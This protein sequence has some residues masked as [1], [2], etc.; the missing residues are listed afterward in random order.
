MKFCAWCRRIKNEKT[1]QWEKIP[2]EFPPDTYDTICPDCKNKLLGRHTKNRGK[3]ER[4]N[5]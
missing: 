1:D 3:K 5:I 4:D 2:A